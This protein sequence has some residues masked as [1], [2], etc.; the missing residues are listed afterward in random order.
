MTTIATVTAFI[1]WSISRTDAE[2][3]ARQATLVERAMQDQIAAVPQRQADLA[4]G[5]EALTA[6]ASHDTN[7]LNDHVGAPAYEKHGQNRVYLLDADTNPVYAMRDGDE[8][9]AA[10]FGTVR[11]SVLPLIAQLH[12][13]GNLAVIE[14]YNSFI[15]GQMPSVADV[16]LLDDQPAIVSVMPM[17]PAMSMDFPQLGREPVYV[18]AVLLD[19]QMA[20]ALSSQYLFTDARFD[21]TPTNTGSEAALAI[22]GMNGRPVAWFIW[23]PDRPGARM[24]GDT[25]PALLGALAVAGTIIVLLMRN[26]Q[27]ASDELQ[28]ERAEAQHRALHDPLTGLGNRSLFEERLAVA[29]QD[30]PRGKPG[31]AVLALDLD[32]FKQVNDTL[33]HDAGDELLRQV[34]AR[35]TATLRATDTLVRFGGD[36]FA[37]IQIGINLHSD[38]GRLAQRVIDRLHTPF[39]LSGTPV[40]IGVSIGIATAP[41]LAD[42]QA[43]LVKLADEALYLAKSG[44]RNRYC[45][46]PEIVLPAGHPVQLNLAVQQAFQPRKA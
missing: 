16:A 6:I 17:L 18:A 14:A 2:A 1:A 5:D 7:W 22:R 40:E 23:Q 32:R 46:N 27:R 19:R 9:P 3:L 38:A 10:S 8:A 13:P 28:A 24:L 37:I 15:R 36:E 45:F 34:G 12:S 26:L 29:L 20:M 11:A 43:D 31:I 33:G 4:I 21:I 30:L 44:G 25:L 39:Q 42:N 35:I 41:D